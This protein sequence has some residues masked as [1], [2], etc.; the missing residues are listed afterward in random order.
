M[1]FQI[2]FC[3]PTIWQNTTP[4]LSN[5]FFAPYAKSYP[6]NISRIH[7]HFFFT[8]WSMNFCKIDFIVHSGRKI[9]NVKFDFLVRWRCILKSM[10]NVPNLKG[11]MLAGRVNALNL[12][13]RFIVSILKWLWLRSTKEFSPNGS[14]WFI[15]KRFRK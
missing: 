6:P 3:K 13:L 10:T 14:L 5:F 11:A 8:F 7:A 4:C 2:C 1:Q 9:E 12:F 15:T